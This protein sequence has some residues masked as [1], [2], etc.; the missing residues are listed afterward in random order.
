MSKTFFSRFSLKGGSRKIKSKLDKLF[1]FIQVE[2][3]LKRIIDLLFNLSSRIVFFRI[4]KFFLLDSIKTVL[5]APREI[6]SI[7]S[8]PVPANKSKQSMPSVSNCIQ[9]NKTSL[10]LLDVGLREL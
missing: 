4:W 6:A 10:N 3:S 1:S 2:A 9:L 8:E 5:F 7:P